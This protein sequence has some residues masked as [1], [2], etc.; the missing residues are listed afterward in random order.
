MLCDNKC[1]AL[2]GQQEQKMGVA[3]MR[4]LRYMSGYKRKDKF[5]NDC[6]QEKVGVVLIKEK[7]MEARLQWVEHV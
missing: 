5:Q 1:W 3:E 6:I 4:M 2:K 7:M